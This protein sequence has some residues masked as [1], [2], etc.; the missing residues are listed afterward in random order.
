MTQDIARDLR[1]R[2]APEATDEIEVT[3]EMIEAG[4][5]V[6]ARFYLGD[7]IYDVREPCLRELYR[8]MVIRSKYPLPRYQIS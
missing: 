8:A 6:L 4:S 2:S 3:P 7:G 5:M 1:D